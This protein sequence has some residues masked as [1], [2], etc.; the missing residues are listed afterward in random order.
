MIRRPTM[1]IF[2]CSQVMYFT[3]VK[4]VFILNIE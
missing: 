2:M 4:Y 1:H 3:N